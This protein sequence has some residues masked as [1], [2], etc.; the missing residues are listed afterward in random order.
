MTDRLDLF[1]KFAPPSGAP[2]SVVRRVG[3]RNAFLGA[4]LF[5]FGVMLVLSLDKLAHGA[6]LDPTAAK[7]SKL[8]AVSGV[9]VVVGFVALVVGFYRALTGIHPERERRTLFPSLARLFAVAV[10]A[11]ALL[12][13]LTWALVSV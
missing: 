7:P 12:A 8:R 3:L 10:L 4:V 1:A 6:L 9:P 2:P 13:A 11:A 5:L